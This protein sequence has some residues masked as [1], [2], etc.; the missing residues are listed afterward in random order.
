MICVFGGETFDLPQN[1]VHPVPCFIFW[2]PRWSI[3]LSRNANRVLPEC[4]S[5][6]LLLYPSFHSFAVLSAT[7]YQTYLQ[8][9]KQP[10]EGLAH[11]PQFTPEMSV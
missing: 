1:V 7:D 2:S 6:V 4:R 9:M 3:V 5:D 10:L 8:E 11:T